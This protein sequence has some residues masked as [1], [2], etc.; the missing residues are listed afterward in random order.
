MT[1]RTDTNKSKQRRKPHNARRV[2]YGSTDELLAQIAAEP[3]TVRVGEREVTMPR[4]ELLWRVRVARALAGNVRELKHLLRIMA[5]RPALAATF[6]EEFVTV[7]SGV[8][9]RV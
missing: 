2:D 1:K 7:V 3:R 6:R 4:I 5:K 8:L 9:A